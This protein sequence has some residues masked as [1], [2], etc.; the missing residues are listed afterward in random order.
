MDTSTDLDT[1]HA[2][3]A[4]AAAI[5][6]EPVRRIAARSYL[7]QRG[8]DI[9]DLPGGWLIGYAPP[10]W[11]RLVDRLHALFPDQAL[12]DAGVASRS[13][14]ETLI[15]TF[16]DRLILGVHDADGQL[17]GFIGRD[18]SGE[19]AAPKYLNTRQTPLFDK[20]KLLFGLS[21]GATGDNRLGCPVLVEGALDVLAIAARAHATG[22][23]SVLPV[24]PSGT[25]FTR[26]QAQLLA[27]VAFDRQ[28][29]VVVAMDGDAAGRR[30]GILAGEQLRAFGLDVRVAVLPNGSD[31]AECMSRPGVSLETFRP[32]H[33]LPLLTLRVE[34]AIAGQGDR[35][36][37]IEGRLAAARTI[38]SYLTSY[39]PSYAAQQIVWLADTLD[40]QRETV[41][42]ELAAAYVRR[43][44]HS[45]ERRRAALQATAPGSKPE[46]V[47]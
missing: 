45:S 6:T 22:N 47:R 13:S 1:L 4:D 35:M 20:G 19:Y 33:G 28:S 36:Q 38:A 16:R 43:P 37:W 15:D 42:G 44:N 29:P 30:A 25:A 34:E 32:A 7:R 9:A 24:A 39:P 40:L 26:D 41:T 31:P 17:A 18:L 8:I 2:V 46:M 23:A 12:I 14:R 5:F 3:T 27:D 11:T 21:E 10:G